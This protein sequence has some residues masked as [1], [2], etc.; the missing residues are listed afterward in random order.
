MWNMVIQKPDLESHQLSES[1]SIDLYPYI[2]QPNYG[3]PPLVAA[4]KG[5]G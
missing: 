5:L 4:L 3:V 1:T 2:T